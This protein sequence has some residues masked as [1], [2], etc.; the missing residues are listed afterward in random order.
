MLATIE[1]VFLKIVSAVF[2]VWIVSSFQAQANLNNEC[3]TSS[4]NEFIARCSKV[5]TQKVD[6]AAAD[7]LKSIDLKISRIQQTPS[8]AATY[9]LNGNAKSKSGKHDM[10]WVNS[11]VRNGINTAPGA[12]MTV[13]ETSTQIVAKT[14]SADKNAS[15]TNPIEDFTYDKGTRRLLYTSWADGGKMMSYQAECKAKN[16]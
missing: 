1:N 7:D 5:K 11:I 13:T 10:N 3:E 2:L 9:C 16:E 4:K 15:A 14:D 8:E 12:K 6:Q